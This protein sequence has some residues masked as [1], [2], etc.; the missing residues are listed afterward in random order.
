[1][2]L[3]TRN[4]SASSWTTEIYDSIK[5]LCY[6]HLVPDRSLCLRVDFVVLVQRQIIVVAL[7]QDIVDPAN[8]VSSV[9]ENVDDGCQHYNHVRTFV[10][11]ASSRT[12]RR[13]RCCSFYSSQLF[14]SPP[15]AFA[16][17]YLLLFSMPS[18]SSWWRHRVLA[19]AIRSRL[20]QIYG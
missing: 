13:W 19:P 11:Y 12:G 4:I 20:H 14:L 15:V 6:V 2:T 10:I 7:G 3:P 1:M 18:T 9:H 17:S 5:V 16:V 8:I